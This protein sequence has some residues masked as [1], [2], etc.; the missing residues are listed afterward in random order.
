MEHFEN[1]SFVSLSLVFFVGSLWSQLIYFYLPLMIICTINL[2]FF[3]LTA[4]QILRAQQDLKKVTSN[5]ESTRHRSK[6]NSN[7]DR[8]AQI[9]SYSHITI[10]KEYNTNPINFASTFFFHEGMF[11]RF[12]KKAIVSKSTLFCLKKRSSGKEYFLSHHRNSIYFDH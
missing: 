12:T 3:I 8:Y 10:A 9:F 7:K 1:C 5:E 4:M 2:M 11:Q 6:L